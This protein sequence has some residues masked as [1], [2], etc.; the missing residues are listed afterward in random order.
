MRSL[1]IEVVYI[2]ESGK[3]AIHEFSWTFKENKPVEWWIDH[4]GRLYDTTMIDNQLGE[5]YLE[6]WLGPDPADPMHPTELHLEP[7]MFR[8]ANAVRRVTEFRE[9]FYLVIN[10]KVTKLLK[11]I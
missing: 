9:Q 8:G 2:K 7:L 4:L 6:Y 5:E 10:T 11:E 3:R 1:S